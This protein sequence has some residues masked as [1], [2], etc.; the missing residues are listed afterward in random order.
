M[1]V[2]RSWFS[3]PVLYSKTRQPGHQRN[4]VVMRSNLIL[5]VALSLYRGE[6]PFVHTR[7][8]GERILACT[9]FF[10][11]P[12]SP[13]LVWP[14][15]PL[16]VDIWPQGRAWQRRYEIKNQK[17]SNP[18]PPQPCHTNAG[19]YSRQATARTEGLTVKPRILF[20][21]LDACILYDRVAWR[22][23]VGGT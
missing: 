23:S 19:E 4:W 12:W 6:H 2:G 20:P 16:R 18:C 14:H 11:H 9:T 1:V 7:K 21:R 10:L 22:D 17:R 5:P 15:G 13:P 8:A 3:L